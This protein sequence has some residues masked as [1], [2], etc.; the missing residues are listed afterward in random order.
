MALTSPGVEVSVINESFY[1]PSDAGTTPLFIVASGTNKAPGSGSGTASGTTTAN[2]NTVY[3]LSSQR[4]L[5]ETFGD[6]KFYTDASGNALHGYELNEWG[7][8]A[9]YSF[10]GIANRA[11]VLRTNVD[12]T[13]LV[14]SASSP[15]A[16]PTDGTYWFDLA[17]SSFGIQEWSKTNQVFTAKTPI[18]ITSVSDLVGNS[19]TGAP[20][21]SIGSVGDYAVNTTHVSNKMYYKNDG[22]A[23]AQLGS[24][25]WHLSHPVVSVASGTAVTTKTMNVNGVTITSG[26]TA[27]SDV[28]AAIA[29]NVTN[30]TAAI[31]TA[32]GNLEIYHNGYALGDSTAGTNTIRFEEGN[33]L[34]AELGITPGTYKGPTFLQSKHTSRPTWKTADDN[35]P[36]GSVWFK[37]TSANSGTNVIAKLYDSTSGSWG[38]VSSPLYATNHS[39]IYNTDPTNGGTGI[40]AGTLYA[41]YN[42]TEEGIA[43]ADAADTTPNVGD[44]Q[45]F[46][47]EGAETIISSKTVYP[48]NLQGKFTCSESVKN[49]EA[50]V[51]KIVT[52]ANQDGSTIADAE[53]FV[54]GFAAANFTNLEAS[55]IT[56]GNYKGAIQIKHKLGGEFRMVDNVEGTPLAT[57]GFSTSTAHA[58]GGYTANSTTLIDNLYAAPTGETMDSSA[59]HGLVASN[60]KRLSYTAGIDAPS[61][62][63][64]R[65]FIMV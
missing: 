31:D 44:L 18:L 37:T 7:L 53:D 50:L 40:A 24:S 45:L 60:W 4:E 52:V 32:T 47:Y 42:I 39:A 62:E 20:K 63:A 34:L 64:S 46:R 49:A 2:A 26:G 28:V 14:G 10:L 22:G 27:L 15:T 30:V 9:A 59:N 8:Q 51:E 48:L 19:S 41:Q 6:P 21:T 54:T 38:T 58:Y 56:S 1:V 12:L 13:E 25:A 55:I 3:L 36:N 33:G 11:Y 61:N 35:R 5:T 23:W 65:W 43:S 17:S 29:S 57:A 16:N